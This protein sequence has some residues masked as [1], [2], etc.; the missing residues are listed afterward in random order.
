[1]AGDQ[2]KITGESYYNLPGGN[3]GPPLTMTVTEL[4]TSLVGSPT[5]PINKSLTVTDLNTI[6]GNTSQLGT[7]INGNTPP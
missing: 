4:L 7:F 3:A 2:V 5:V 1:M 6:P